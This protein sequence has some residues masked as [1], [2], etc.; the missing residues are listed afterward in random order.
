MSK[1]SYILLSKNINLNNIKIKA[2]RNRKWKINPT[3]SV[4]ETLRFSSYKNRKSKVKLWWNGARER[5]KRAFSVPLILSEGKFF[6]ICVL[7]QCIVY[8]IPFQNI[9][10]F[11]YQKNVTSYTF[12]PAFKIVKSLQCIINGH[13]GKRLDM[14]FR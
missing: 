10:S 8:W 9:Q 13:V 3:H 12:L 5:K 7:S 14:K 6:N 11:T 1:S 2:K 4:R